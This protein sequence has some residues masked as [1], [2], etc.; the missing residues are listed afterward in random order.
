MKI[1]L[2]ILLVVILFKL[3]FLKGK[4][5]EQ[6]RDAIDSGEHELLGDDYADPDVQESLQR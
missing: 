2:I 1:A 3:L 5:K 4:N 6:I